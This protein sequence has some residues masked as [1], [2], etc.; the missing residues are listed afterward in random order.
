[1]SATSLSAAVSVSAPASGCEI[2]TFTAPGEADPS[3]LYAAYVSFLKSTSSRLTLVDL[4]SAKLPPIAFAGI[5]IL[6]LHVAQ[7]ERRRRRGGR[8]AIVCA[9]E[10]DSGLARVFVSLVSAEGDPVRFAVFGHQDAAR[11]W[12]RA[13]SRRT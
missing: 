3:D 5:R 6:A 4:S 11:A 1:M 9:R 2:S 13:E 8:S 7:I 12:L 10:A